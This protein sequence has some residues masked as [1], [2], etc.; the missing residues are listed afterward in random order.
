MRRDR[1][2]SLGS[3]AGVSEPSDPAAHYLT[4]E[5]AAQRLSLTAGALRARCRRHA[6]R[7]GRKVIA[8][9]G[10]GIVAIKMG[11]SWRLRFP[12]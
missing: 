11:T 2:Q 3:S 4:V 9:M 12:D 8:H 6:R 10:G 5:A 1:G 7:E